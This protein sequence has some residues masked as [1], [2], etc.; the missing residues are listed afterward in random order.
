M[1][2]GY[3][4]G[5]KYEVTFCQTKVWTLKARHTANPN[6]PLLVLPGTEGAANEIRKRPRPCLNCEEGGGDARTAMNEQESKRP[7]NLSQI[8]TH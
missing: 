7:L 5:Q 2:I 1:F 6:Q 3:K 4:I 8:W